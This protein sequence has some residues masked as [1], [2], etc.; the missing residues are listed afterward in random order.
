MDTKQEEI[1]NT[2]QTLLDL[3]NIKGTIS[4]SN[5]T[6]TKIEIK[7]EG[8]NLG[9]LIGFRG[10]TLSAVQLF[11]ELSHFRKNGEW[12]KIFLDAGNFR[13]EK[14]EQIKAMPHKFCDKVTFFAKPI[15]LPAMSSYERMIV[16]TVVGTFPNLSSESVGEGRTR[17]VVISV[18]NT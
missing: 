7:V 2:L 5:C 14:E 9:A 4:F 11:L 12:V 10:D 8:E 13:A 17:H 6:D 18:K 1:K 15:E 16:H 3:L